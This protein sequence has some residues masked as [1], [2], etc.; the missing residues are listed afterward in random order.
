MSSLDRRTFL[1]A[2]LALAACG[3]TPVYAPGGTAATLRGQVMVQAPGTRDAFLLV[4]ELERQLGRSADPQYGLKLSLTVTP[5]GLA[6]TR[7][8]SVTRYNLVGQA[9]YALV[10]IAD[11]TEIAKGEV[12][13]FTAYSTAGSTVETLAAERDA[14]ERLMTILASQITARLYAQADLA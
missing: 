12:E 7:S 9:T 5:E 4:Q 1:I 6:V 10:R 14:R 13:N 11:E 8:G 2:P 3:F